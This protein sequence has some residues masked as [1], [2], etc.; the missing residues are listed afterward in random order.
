MNE[1]SFSSAPCVSFVLD[2]TVPAVSH[3][4]CCFCS[5]R[6]INS[7]LS[8]VCEFYPFPY[9]FFL[10]PVLLVCLVWHVIIQSSHFLLGYHPFI[11]FHPL[12][13]LLCGCVRLCISPSALS[14]TSSHGEGAYAFGARGGNSPARRGDRGETL[15]R[16]R[17]DKPSVRAKA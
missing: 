16:D 14:S 11:S 15:L 2:R 5:H 4:A 6:S 7:V 17:E 10:S 12:M 1:W 9:F 3:L 8:N 13:A